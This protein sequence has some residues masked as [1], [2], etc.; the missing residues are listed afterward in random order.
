MSTDSES[1][2]VP[3]F[4]DRFRQSLAAADPALET[5]LAAMTIQY[6]Q[7]CD[8]ANRRLRE[9][10]DLS[11]K[12]QYANAVALADQDPNLMDRCSLLE[13]PERDILST[14][15]SALGIKSPSL[16]NRDLVEA[17]QD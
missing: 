4:I 12:G 15:A 13:I 3:E 14:V 10:F 8:A 2:D 17:L 9:C 16:L 5:E 6:G 1:L 11:Q 7:L